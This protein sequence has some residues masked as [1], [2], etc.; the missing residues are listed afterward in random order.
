VELTADNRRSV[1]IPGGFAHGYQTLTDNT[2]LMY[3]I[4]ERYSPPHER[5]VRWND[6]AFGIEWPHPTPSA[7]HPR[8]SS[9]PDFDQ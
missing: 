6:P 2:E 5:G 4:S 9:Y 3:F 8:D 1:Y 7:I